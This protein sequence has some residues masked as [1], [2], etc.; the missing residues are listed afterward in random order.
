MECEGFRW[1]VKDLER[2]RIKNG[3]GRLGNKGSNE[4][5]AWKL[6]GSNSQT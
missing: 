1:N 6:A 2:W 4:W 5:K 3:L